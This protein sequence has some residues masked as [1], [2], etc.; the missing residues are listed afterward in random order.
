M[1]KLLNRNKNIRIQSD[2]QTPGAEERGKELD[3]DILS[4]TLEENGNNT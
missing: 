3:E 4:L 2:A 1:V